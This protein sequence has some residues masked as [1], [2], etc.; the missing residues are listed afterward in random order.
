MVTIPRARLNKLRRNKQRSLGLPGN[1]TVPGFYPNRIGAK[2]LQ[3]KFGW[4]GPAITRLG[5]TRRW[6]IAQN[7]AN[8]IFIE[9]GKPVETLY[10]SPN[11]L[12]SAARLAVAG[13]AAKIWAQAAWAAADLSLTLTGATVFGVR[14]RITNSVL[15][16][17]FGAVKIGIL[18]GAT[19]LSTITVL[20]AQLPVDLIALTIN[21]A[22]GRAT[23]VG[24]ANPIVRFLLADNTALVAGDQLYAESLNARDIGDITGEG[25]PCS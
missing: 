19:V 22:A 2:D 9:P 11:E 1:G 6:A 24:V 7:N 18:S 17:K 10:N 12:L 15:N 5:N 3:Y 14:I 20:S 25:A 13:N 21:D 16:Y 23:I 4:V 8:Q